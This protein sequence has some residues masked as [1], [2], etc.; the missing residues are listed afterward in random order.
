MS[1]CA[2][3]IGGRLL[4][5]VRVA[6]DYLEVHPQTLRR[7]ARLGLVEPMVRRGRWMFTAAQL[8]HLQRIM[9]EQRR[10][11]GTLTGA[12]RRIA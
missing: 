11:G 9:A 6:A 10:D 1:A 4:V 8:A 3:A 5:G 12:A 2:P 7:Y